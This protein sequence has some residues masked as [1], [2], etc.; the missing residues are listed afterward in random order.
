MKTYIWIQTVDGSILQV[1]QEVAL[2]SPKLCHQVQSGVGS[3]KSNPIC[4]P[5]QVKPAILPAIF[6]YYKFHQ[7][8]GLSDKVN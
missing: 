1:E 5:Q 8:P 2:L 3:T 7:A 4:V 6:D